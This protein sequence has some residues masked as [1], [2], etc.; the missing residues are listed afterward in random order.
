MFVCDGFW[1]SVSS[2]VY[3]DM[4]RGGWRE[5]ALQMGYWNWNQANDFH[6]PVCG[7]KSVEGR[8]HRGGCCV[9][10]PFSKNTLV[11]IVSFIHPHLFIQK[12]KYQTSQNRIINGRRRTHNSLLDPNSNELLH[13]SRQFKRQSQASMF[14]PLQP[15][16]QQVFILIAR[17]LLPIR[18]QHRART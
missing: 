1:C 7:C 9:V 8:E 17:T 6:T 14:I 3:F 2:F 4:R 10:E 12:L 15:M 13:K 16:R 18:P 5:W 11:L